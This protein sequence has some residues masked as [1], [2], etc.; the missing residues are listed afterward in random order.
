MKSWTAIAVL[1]VAAGVARADE[2]VLRNGARFEGKVTESGDS[3]TVVMDFGSM[4]FRK[5]DVARIDRGL[6]PLSDFEAKKAALHP[7]DLDGRV[8]LARWG[9]QKELFH[10]SRR[11]LEDVI[12][13]DPDHAGAREALGYRRVGGRWLTDD[14]I[15]VEQGLVLFRG[16]WVKQDTVDEILKIEAQRALEEARLDEMEMLRT[17]ALEAEAAAARAQEEARAAYDPYYGDY[18]YR[19]PIYFTTFWGWRGSSCRPANKPICAS[20]PIATPKPAG[21]PSSGARSAPAIP[22]ARR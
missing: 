1:A 12:V 18:Y 11:L 8:R 21:A 5:M 15:K 20:R 9:R 13:V 22:R 16:D 14:E 3:V 19:R 7:D 4:T 6:T 10:H 17:R 2:V